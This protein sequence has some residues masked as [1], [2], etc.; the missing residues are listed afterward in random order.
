MKGKDKSLLFK[1]HLTFGKIQKRA[2]QF[3]TNNKRMLPKKFADCDVSKINPG[4]END[5]EI[6]FHFINGKTLKQVF[7]IISDTIGQRLI[8]SINQMLPMRIPRVIPMKLIPKTPF[9]T[10]ISF[11]VYNI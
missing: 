2:K 7:I 4:S 5:F 1:K 11:F 9:L 3:P 8:F 10:V 6:K